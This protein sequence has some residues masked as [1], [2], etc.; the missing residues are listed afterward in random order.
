MSIVTITLEDAPDGSIGIEIGVRSF[1]QT[2]NAVALGEQVQAYI[3]G[4][5]DE[6]TKPVIS[7]LPT[8]QIDLS[9]VH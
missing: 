9:A 3:A 7:M 6:A 5:V 2:S 4:V 8:P 1:S